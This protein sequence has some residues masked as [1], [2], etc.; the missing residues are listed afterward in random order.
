MAGPARP[1]DRIELNDLKQC[2]DRIIGC[3][4]ERDAD[5]SVI[6]QFHEE[7]GTLT[8]RENACKPVLKKGYRV[9]ID[10]KEEIIDNGS[11]V[12]AAITSCTNTSNPFVL[13]GAG[14]LAKNAVEKGLQVPGTVKTS[15]APGSRVVIRYLE[16]AGL[17]PYLEALG[18]HLAAFGCTTCIGNSGPLHPEIEKIIT[19]K[20]T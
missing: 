14:L 8:S 10:G 11:I 15:L 7:S 3:Q 19:E 1:Q 4:Y 16:D 5:K 17:M 9:T 2:F 13:L 12:V 20:K 6:S 18:F